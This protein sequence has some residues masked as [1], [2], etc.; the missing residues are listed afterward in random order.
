ML[1]FMSQATKGGEPDTPWG[2]MSLTGVELGVGVPWL[3]G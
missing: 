3:P 2:D 1:G